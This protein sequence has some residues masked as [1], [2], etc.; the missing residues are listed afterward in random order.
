MSGAALL[1]ALVL[2]PAAQLLDVWVD[3]EELVT[4]ACLCVVHLLRTYTLVTS[5]QDWQA[6]ST[7]LHVH[8]ISCQINVQLHSQHGSLCMQTASQRVKGQVMR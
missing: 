7:R 8:V 4:C 6:Q 5:A 1:F 3:S 2:D